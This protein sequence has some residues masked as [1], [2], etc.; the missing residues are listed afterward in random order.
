MNPI[1]MTPAQIRRE[2]LAALIERLGPGGAL[3]F[4][5]LCGVSLGDY[6]AERAEIIRDLTLETLL[7][8]VKQT[9]RSVAE[10]S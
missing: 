2:G 9:E 10:P 4:I 6:T 5:R 3:A 7:S 8:D 1:R